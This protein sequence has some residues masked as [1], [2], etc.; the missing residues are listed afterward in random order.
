MSKYQINTIKEV[1]G[2]EDKEAENLINLMDTTGDHP[3]WSEA[4]NTQLRNHFKMVL[5]GL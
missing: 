4:S 2:F 1:M 3:D 5:L